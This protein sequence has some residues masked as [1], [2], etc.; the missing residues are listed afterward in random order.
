MLVLEPDNVLRA[1]R[2]GQ[3]L[4]TAHEALRMIGAAL[5][6]AAVTPVQQGLARRFPLVDDQGPR[7]LLIHGVG[8]AVQALG[9]VVLG[10]ML[11]AW[12]FEGKLAPSLGEIGDELA[13]NWTLLV[14]AVGGFT[15]VTELLRLGRRKT[16]VAP[17]T[18]LDRSG[19][20][21]TSAG[22]RARLIEL[23]TVDW[24]ESQGNYVALHV[25]PKAHLIRR[26]L[27]DVEASLDAVRF[28]RIHR[29]TIVAIDRIRAMKPLT[30]GDAMAT[31]ADGRELRVSRSYRDEVRRRWLNA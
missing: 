12:V 24:I 11:A 20:I 7:N 27:R 22:A 1:W 25:G 23:Q 28:T 19:L 15:A 5:L 4:S 2:M 6:G 16:S 8:A 31:L 10:C 3:P 18:S 26:T 14:F 21:A 30:N 9:L 29:S 13:A 17:K